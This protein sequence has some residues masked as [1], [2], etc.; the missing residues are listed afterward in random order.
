MRPTMCNF[1]SPRIKSGEYV[2]PLVT[3]HGTRLGFDKLNKVSVREHSMS[4]EKRFFMRD[5]KAKLDSA[6][7]GPC[8][9]DTAHPF[10]T[11]ESRI[12]SSHHVVSHFFLS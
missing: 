3:P 8:S 11:I 2:H 10:K 6:L 4:L 1:K 5:L 7:P 12:N 9:N